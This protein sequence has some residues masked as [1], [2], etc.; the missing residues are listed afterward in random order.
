MTEK[1]G[2]FQPPQL[3]GEKGERGRGRGF[4]VKLVLDRDRLGRLERAFYTDE[5]SPKHVTA[6]VLERLS[7]GSLGFEIVRE[8]DGCKDQRLGGNGPTGGEHL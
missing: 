7:L 5:D 4:H 8:S 3:A 6:P 1:V 2:L